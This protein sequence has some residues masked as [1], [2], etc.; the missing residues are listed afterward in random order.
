MSLKRTKKGGEERISVFIELLPIYD[1]T[2][3]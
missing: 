3:L 2:S 1:Y